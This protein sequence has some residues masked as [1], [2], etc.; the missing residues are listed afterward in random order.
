MSAVD[1]MEK[2]RAMAGEASKPKS[3]P[4]SEVKV[5]VVAIDT[6]PVTDDE[7]EKPICDTAVVVLDDG[8]TFSLI[9]GARVCWVNAND[10]SISA[11]TYGDGVPV[12]ELLAL[13]DAIRTCVT[14]Q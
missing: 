2:L 4:K 7:D 11:I 5:A 10:D 1:M 8:Q 13:R 12:S 9:E 3:K 14:R 6:E